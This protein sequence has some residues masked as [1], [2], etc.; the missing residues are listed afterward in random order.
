MAR[1]AQL[2][3]S[4]A[5]LFSLVLLGSVLLFGAS[6]AA[7]KQGP[8]GSVVAAFSAFIKAPELTSSDYFGFSVSISGDRAII[9]A[10][11]EDSGIPGIVMNPNGN[12]PALTNNSSPNSG[13]AY[14]IERNVATDT[15]TV[16]A[17][18][19][20]PVVA[21][22]DRFGHSVSI[23]GERAIIGAPEEEAS[24]PGIVMNPDGTERALTFKHTSTRE[25]G[26]AYVLER[27][28]STGIWSFEAFVKPPAVSIAR[29][30]ERQSV[31]HHQATSP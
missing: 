27:D 5:L 26:A 11:Q 20:P 16:V 2:R 13:A 31:S 7:G 18:V 25:S 21:S 12:E 23:S 24:T 17:Y 10:P 19:K 30:S 4:P 9:G 15:W 8:K 1:A 3:G 29:C 28:S 6:P 14:I 22:G